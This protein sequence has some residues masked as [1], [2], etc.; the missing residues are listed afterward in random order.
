MNIE[1][2]I[3][4]RSV[5]HIVKNM[6]DS[7][8]NLIDFGRESSIDSAESKWQKIDNILMGY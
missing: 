1:T 7:G 2:D 3:F 8:E 5:Y 4:V 6:G